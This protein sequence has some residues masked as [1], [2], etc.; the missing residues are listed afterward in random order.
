MHPKRS[1]KSGRHS[2]NQC[3]CEERI[4]NSSNLKKRKILNIQ[5]KIFN[6]ILLLNH[7]ELNRLY[8]IFQLYNEFVS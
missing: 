5:Y 8:P 6:N 7:Y 2:G 4:R 1:V 3:S